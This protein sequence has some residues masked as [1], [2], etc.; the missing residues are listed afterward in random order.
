MLEDLFVSHCST[1]YRSG[2]KIGIP[3]DESDCRLDMSGLVAITRRSPRAGLDEDR[4][5]G[6]GE[7]GEAQC[8]CER[9][10]TVLRDWGFMI[11]RRVFVRGGIAV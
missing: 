11:T 4:T 1:A 9:A 10:A 8:D 5:S 3:V 7:V 2:N 6:S